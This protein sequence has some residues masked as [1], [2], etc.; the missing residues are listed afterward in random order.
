MKRYR[1]T[2]LFT[3]MFTGKSRNVELAVAFFKLILTNAVFFSVHA[4]KLRRLA[5]MQAA[6]GLATVG[7]SERSEI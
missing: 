5:H 1:Y 7:Q 6:L 4:C 3:A 2:V